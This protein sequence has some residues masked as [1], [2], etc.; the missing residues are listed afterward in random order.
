MPEFILDIETSGLDPL[1][2][3]ISCIGLL[4]TNSETL[5]QFSGPVEEK[6]L[7]DFWFFCN[8]AKNTFVGYNLIK[9]DIYFLEIRSLIHKMKIFRL[10][11]TDLIYPLHPNGVKFHSRADWCKVLGINAGDHDGSLLPQLFL[12]G[13]FDLIK[14]HN[15]ADL[16]SELEMLH[17]LR[18]CNFL[19]N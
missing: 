6:L 12:K 14:K 19:R 5:K 9:F 8:G 15:E 3:S 2:H 7:N 13:E 17:R 16:R 4:D 10:E 11:G 1:E 18:E